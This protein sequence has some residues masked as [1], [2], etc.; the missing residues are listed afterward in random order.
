LGWSFEGPLVC[1]PTWGAS[2]TDST[3]SCSSAAAFL[4]PLVPVPP[5]LLPGSI[6]AASGA[7]PAARAGTL[8]PHMTVQQFKS[9]LLAELQAAAHAVVQ[10]AVEPAVQAAMQPAVHAAVQAAAQAVVQA[11]V[12]AAAGGL[13]WPSTD[14]PAGVAGGAGAAGACFANTSAAA[15]PTA[16]TA[17]S[18]PSAPVPRS[19][20]ALPISPA[21]VSGLRCQCVESDT[22]AVA[23]QAARSYKGGVRGEQRPQATLAA[24]QAKYDAGALASGAALPVRPAVATSA[25]SRH[26]HGV[27]ESA[28]AGDTGTEAFLQAVAT[29]VASVGPP[30]AA[31][32]AANGALQ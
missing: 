20:Q 1:A 22:H 26:R 23:M 2:S 8:V 27:A 21:A 11:A 12:Q 18:A 19:V 31:S 28:A 9:H 32:T 14:A 29:F 4:P 6:S 13:A 16:P 5:G 17:L 25:G 15:A 3:S 24:A 10:A 7:V 30:A